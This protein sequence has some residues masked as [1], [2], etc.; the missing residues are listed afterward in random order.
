[1][2]VLEVKNLVKI[3]NDSEIKVKAVDGIDLTF[4]KR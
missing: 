1:M 3:Y 4:E 2:N